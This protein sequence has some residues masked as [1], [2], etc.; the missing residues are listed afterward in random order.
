MSCVHTC[1]RSIQL[2]SLLLKE[3]L[4]AILLLENI[5]NM[6]V[7][8][9]LNLPRLKITRLDKRL[10]TAEGDG[11]LLFRALVRLGELRLLLQLLGGSIMLLIGLP[12]T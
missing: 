6:A 2:C 4:V 7:F 3:L 11:M 5:T 1:V 9:G 10:L 12:F 8:I